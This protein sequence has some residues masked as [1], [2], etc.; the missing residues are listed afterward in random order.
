M[1]IL[2]IT[3]KTDL[4]VD[5]HIADVVRKSNSSMFALRTLKS[6]RLKPDCLW[7][8]CR[9]TMISRIVY[10]SSAWRGFATQALVE[11]LEAIIR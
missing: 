1:I 9:A 2:G 6:M 3:I 5:D 10:G 7:T 4:S 8:V 11:R